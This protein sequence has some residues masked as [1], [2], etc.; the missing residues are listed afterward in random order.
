MSQ[1]TEEMVR[2]FNE[3]FS[4]NDISFMAENLAEEVTWKKAGDTLITGKQEVLNLLHVDGEEGLFNITLENIVCE[5]PLSMCNGR[6]EVTKN[7]GTV[8]VYE[9]S[10][11][12][13]LNEENKIKELTSYVVKSIV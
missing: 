3:A 11:V 13:K 10:E 6:R 4:A 1:H 12:Y 8:E 7:D 2:A 9:F 5:G